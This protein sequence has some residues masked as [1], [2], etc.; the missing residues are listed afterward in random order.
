MVSTSKIEINKRGGGDCRGTWDCLEIHTKSSMQH[1]DG[2]F[3]ACS[4]G[5]SAALEKLQDSFR[6]A[7]R[8]SLMDV[9][10]AKQREVCAQS[11]PGVAKTN[12][13]A[14]KVWPLRTIPLTQVL[15]ASM[16]CTSR[17]IRCCFRP[18]KASR[19]HT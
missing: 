14:N 9:H 8:K 16:M 6:S 1:P 10:P 13:G 18:T 3:P 17:T 5:S 15:T 2:R 4:G 12:M 19:G 11:Q 7:L